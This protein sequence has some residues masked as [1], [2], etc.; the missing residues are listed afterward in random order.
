MTYNVYLSSTLSDLKAER[1]AVHSVLRGECVVKDSYR[2][3]EK[4]LTQSCM[5]DVAACDLYI[6]I[7]GLRYGYVPKNEVKNPNALSITEL[8]YQHAVDAGKP[9]L[10]FIKNEDNIPVPQADLRGKEN[11]PERIEALRERCSD[12]KDQRSAQFGTVTDLREAVLK[13]F[14]TF[15]E[16]AAARS[17]KNR[18]P[19]IEVTRNSVLLDLAQPSS[20]IIRARYLEWVRTECERVVLLGLDMRD[21][22]NMR[23]GQV[24]VPA[25][26]NPR[27]DKAKNPGDRERL[28][29]PDS[30]L[31]LHRLGEES[32]YVPGAPGAGKS[33]F[34]RWLALCV[35]RGDVPVHPLGTS[36][37]LEETL[38]D[39]LRNRFP[40]LCSLRQWSGHPECLAGNGTWMRK[41]LED[42]LACWIDAA[43]PGDLTSA[44]LREELTAGRC[45]LIFDGVDEIP[46]RFGKHFPRRNFL[47]GLA[48]AAQT[49]MKQGNRILL[50]SRPYGVSGGEQAQLGLTE[51]KLLELPRELQAAFID[52]WYA[53]A[54]GERGAVKSRGLI[55]HL[56]G[57]PDLN[58]LRNNPMLLTALCVKYDEGQR[59]P[60][61]LYRLYEAVV[62]QVLYKRYQTEQD[63][64]LARL[65]LGAIALRMHTGPQADPRETPAAEASFEEIDRAL[66]D[67]TQSDP[68]SERGGLDASTRRENLLSESGLLLTRDER[69]AGFY[70]LSF[71][72]FLAAVQVRKTDE[73]IGDVL[74]RHAAIPAWRRTLRF[75]FCAMPIR[76]ARNG[77]CAS[78]HRCSRI[79]NRRSSSA[80]RIRP[81]S[82]RIASKSA[83]CADGISNASM[84]RSG[85]P[86]NTRFTTSH[87]P[88][89]RTCGG[90]SVNLVS[91]T[92]PASA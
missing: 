46:E 37:E 55:E 86:A 80:I 7:I 49:W 71:Q 78:S 57:R 29:Q 59:L 24:Y 18:R 81:C 69:K 16:G 73:L 70:H 47:S 15:K 54:E 39:T 32:L 75:L 1:E 76:N 26:T 72:E 67:L 19:F 64:D 3:S 66:A 10:L 35:A 28:R 27:E 51:A 89:A 17:E 85:G 65:R 88:R 25:L 83:T 2:A 91:M 4:E 9:R 8:E 68:A 11:Q 31:L 20:A 44:V 50:T 22:Q 53:A 79:W 60:G 58:D 5:D 34:S 45:L 36:K 40:L 82:S 92:G 6:G 13:A 23:L 12:G 84:R 77:P 14:N 56:D 33:T 43:R 30:V 61:D 90:S 87:R 21:R 48:D 52:R 63:R 41:Q 38:P 74:V 62:S 42:S